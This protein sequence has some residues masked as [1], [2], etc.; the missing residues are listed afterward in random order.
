[1]HLSAPVVKKALSSMLFTMVLGVPLVMK[2][3]SYFVFKSVALFLMVFSTDY[4]YDPLIWTDLNVMK[5]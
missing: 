3:M 4:E 5:F 1:M 2:R